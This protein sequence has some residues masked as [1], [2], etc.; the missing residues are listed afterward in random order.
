[1]TRSIAAIVFV[2]ALAGLS[3][4]ESPHASANDAAVGVANWSESRGCDPHEAGITRPF[5]SRSGSIPVNERIRGPWGDMFGRTY[6]QVNDAL[7]AWHLPGSSKTMYVH[8]KT[9]PA[10][11][12]AGASLQAHQASGKSY[13]VYSAY[14]RNWRTVGGSYR[15]SEHAF[16]TAFDINPGSN[17]WS[18]DNVLRTNLPGWFVDSFADAG[19]CWGGSWVDSK[20]AMHFSWSG[21]AQTPNYPARVA[22]Y[23]AVTAATTY[24]ERLVGFNIS[25]TASSGTSMTVADMT[26]EGAPD[27]VL[28]SPSGLIEASGAVGNYS[29]IAF[30]SNAGSG[31][32]ETLIGD[33]DLDGVAD[34]WVP[35]RDGATVSFSVWA[36]GSDHQVKTDVTSGIPTTADRLLLGYY[37][38]D[39]VPDLYALVGSQFNVYGSSNG[40]TAA[41]AQ[42]PLPAG[43]DGSWHFATGDLDL[44]GKADIYAISNAGAPTMAVRLATGGIATFSPAVN[45]TPQ[46]M[47]EIADYDGDGRDDVYTLNGSELTIALGGHSSG[48]ADSWFQNSSTLPPDAGPKCVGPNPCDSIGHVDSGGVWTL[49]DR[50]RT[51]PDETEFYYGKPG[52]SPFMGDWDNDGI[53]TPG[54]YRRSD[55]FVYLRQTNTQGI[56]DIQFFFGDPGDQ[57]LVGDFDGDGYDTVSIYRPSEHRFYIINELGEDGKGLGAA[58]YFFSFGN[59][60]DI[61]FVG[62]FD[63]DGVD[64]IGLRRSSTARVFLKWELEAGPADYEFIYGVPGDIP[65]AGDWDGN[66]TDTIAVFRPSSGIWYLRLD[67]TAGIAH[68]A[69]RFEAPRGTTL[70]VHG[71]FG[72]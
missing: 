51:D 43:A 9:I 6:Y 65:L 15:P 2:V 31:S 21:P 32:D 60:G 72:L 34:S 17:P 46:T 61:P 7:V 35:K 29:R 13:H 47:F 71:R 16:G 4:V 70:P 63:G 62:D 45:V 40:Y 36:G 8:E 64:E 28:A 3:V 42:L 14:A 52:D 53:D 38:G 37:D 55:G 33:F 11:L 68:H 23:P 26:G 48:A 12:L 67:N 27:V 54:L 30:R 18:H 50:P 39:Y 41:V 5:V 59:P 56:A 66:G 25:L 58:D 22:P 10:L 1:M 20:D 44:D 49:A 24:I 57:P 19:F 69:I